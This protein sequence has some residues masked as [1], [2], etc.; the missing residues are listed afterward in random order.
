MRSYLAAF[1]ITSP[2]RLEPDRAKT[3]QQL[4]SALIRLQ[5]DK[6][7]PSVV[8]LWSPPPDLGAR[9]EIE[10]A[11]ARH[12][13]RRTEL[14]WVAMR[15]EPGIPRIGS[16]LMPAVADAVALRAR[17]AEERGEHALRRLGVHVERLRARSAVRPPPPPA[18]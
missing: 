2:P 14:R 13:R 17:V 7:R 8:Y 6:P 5:R 1:G 16:P 12:P 11:L 10:R 15:V 4:A 18:A 9:P 3:D